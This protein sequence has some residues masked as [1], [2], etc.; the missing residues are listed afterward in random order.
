MKFNLN[1]IEKEFNGDLELSLLRYLRDIENITSPKDGCSPQA[2]CGACTVE[3][4]GK[5]VLSCVIPMKKV[6]GGKVIV[7]S[8]CG[9]R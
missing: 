3:L 4:N 8:L 6:D 7:N 2:S 1:G 9:C 5:A